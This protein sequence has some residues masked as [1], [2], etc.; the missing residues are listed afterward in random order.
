M[1]EA[2]HSGLQSRRFSIFQAIRSLFRQGFTRSKR[3]SQRGQALLEYM[4]L[5]FVGLVFARFIFFHPEFGIKGNIDKFVLRLGAHLETDLKSGTGP[6]G[7]TGAATAPYAG[8]GNW[9]N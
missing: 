9:D 7:D 6:S 8:L 5:L 2:K 1:E 4:L 3:R